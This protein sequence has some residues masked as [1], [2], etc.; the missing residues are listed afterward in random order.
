MS[1]D[2]FLEYGRLLFQ[3][4]QLRKRAA[5]IKKQLATADTSQ[6][7]AQAVRRVTKP[8]LST[9]YSP[10][11]IRAMLREYIDSSGLPV[12]Q[13]GKIIE[14]GD[15][16][17]GRWLNGRR[18]LDKKSLRRLAEYDKPRRD[19]WTA[20][21]RHSDG[22]C[23]ISAALVNE[24]RTR[25]GL[26]RQALSV[27]LGTTLVRVCGWAQGRTLPAPEYCAKFAAIDPL[28]ADAWRKLEKAYRSR[29]SMR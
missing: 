6:A 27:K 9:D 7:P 11:G 3:I 21:A 10:G 5:E 15:S 16:T 26:T 18:Q 17:V 24:I 29:R 20:A 19:Y 14:V 4:S 12:S 22:L 25:D 13:I 2:L 23:V 28:N 1:Q 8:S